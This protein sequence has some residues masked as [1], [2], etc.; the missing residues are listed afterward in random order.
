MSL[1]CLVFAGD[2]RVED[3]SPLLRTLEDLVRATGQGDFLEGKGRLP[4]EACNLRE[5]LLTGIEAAEQQRVKLV[6]RGVAEGTNPE[7]QA[8]VKST[9]TLYDATKK[10]LAKGG[11]G[12][13]RGR[14]L[15]PL[16][17]IHQ[18]D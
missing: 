6:E 16:G 5:D 14:D 18:W 4:D 10:A 2:I 12:G 15:A 9:K 8:L 11:E 3:C 7:W 17:F 13:E 1:L